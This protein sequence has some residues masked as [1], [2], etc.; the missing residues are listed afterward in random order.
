[1]VTRRR[2]QLKVWARTLKRDVMVLWLAAREP[3]VPW[4][5]K[6]LAGAV[7]AYAL[8]P[9]D[10]VPDFIPVLG[11]LDDLLIVPLGVWA[12]VKLIPAP[13]LAELRRQAEQHQR[14]RSV[15]GLAIVA[16]IWLAAAVLTIAVAW[17]MIRPE[18]G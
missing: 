8:S 7:A 16:S 15:A 6:L 9:I 3:H 11:Y 10:L 1:M 4:A 12:A 13:V 14:P 18:S 5:A 17:P 2:E